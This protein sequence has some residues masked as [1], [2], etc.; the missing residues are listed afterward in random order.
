MSWSFLDK[1]LI[2][3]SEDGEILLIDLKGNIMNRV[4][5]S[6]SMIKSFCLSRD[7]SLLLVVGEE[8]GR[9]MDPNELKVFRKFRFE[10]QMNCCAISPLITD[11]DNPKFHCVMAGGI[12][13]R[14]AALV[15]VFGYSYSSNLVLIF[16]SVI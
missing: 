3:S 12:G 11:R 9:L 10:V 4:K 15:K 7:F 1:H 2:A 13:A 14:E 8:G 16:I 6:Q 5:V